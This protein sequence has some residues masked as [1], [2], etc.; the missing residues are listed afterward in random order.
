[1]SQQCYSPPAG[2]VKTAWSLTPRVGSR[3]PGPSPR[4]WSE[5]WVIHLARV[6]RS[7]GYSPRAGWSRQPDSSPR[8]LVKTAG[9]LTARVD[10]AWLFTSRG[11]TKPGYS[12]R[13]GWSRTL[14]S[15]PHGLVKNV[16]VHTA[17]VTQDQ[18]ILSSRVTQDQAILSSRVVNIPD[19]LRAGGRH[20]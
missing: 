7:L 10:E 8:G 17:R 18:A 19:I 11:L 4:G 12:P 15:T 3:Q 13:A 5:A 20:S 16:E 9:F 2:W 1:M 14:K 6:V